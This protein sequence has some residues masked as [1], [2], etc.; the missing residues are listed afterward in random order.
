MLL[1]QAVVPS[2]QE[3]ASISS[4]LIAEVRE[5]VKLPQGTTLV[6]YQPATAI[7]QGQTVFYTLRLRNI[8][9]APVRDATAVQKIPSNTIYVLGSAS[10]PATDITFSTD[11]GQTFGSDS[12]LRITPPPVGAVRRPQA[13]EYTHIRWR[14]HH[15]L[16]PGATALARFQATFQ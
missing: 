9:P 16:A 6:R 15:P 12:Q 4:E 10:G 13:R 7:T 14:L 3:P 11:G 8:S 5:E 1:M 2:A